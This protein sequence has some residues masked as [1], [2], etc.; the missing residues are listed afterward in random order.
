MPKRLGRYLSRRVLAILGGFLAAVLLTVMVTNLFA[1]GAN[2]AG[3]DTANDQPRQQE[4]GGEPTATG[5]QSPR[6][7]PPTTG[8]GVRQPVTA[9]LTTLEPVN[10][11]GPSWETGVVKID[12][13]EYAQGI[14]TD[15]RCDSSFLIEYALSSRYTRLRG[16]A[17]FEDNTQSTAPA[18]FKVYLDNTVALAETIRL[19]KPVKI[20]LDLRGVVRLGIFIDSDPGCDN[21]GFALGDL[22]LDRQ[23]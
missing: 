17:G 3:G 22:I 4:T 9:Y 21:P 10:S 19:R 5:S 23:S 16:T 2:P 20:D 13:R 12:G 15:F 14:W 11:E 6:S 1:R 18:A 7:Q 8:P